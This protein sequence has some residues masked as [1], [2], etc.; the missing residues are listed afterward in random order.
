MQSGAFCRGEF[1][2]GETGVICTAPSM[3]GSKAGSEPV[4]Q[5]SKP[6]FGSRTGMRVCRPLMPSVASVVRM[7]Q[8]KQVIRDSRTPV[9]G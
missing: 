2:F 1:I 9:A 7:V 4:S 3:P 6:S 5:G 8:V